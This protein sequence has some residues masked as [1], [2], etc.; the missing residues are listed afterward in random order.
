M[1][2][3]AAALTRRLA[4]ARR[5][6]QKAVKALGDEIKSSVTEAYASLDVPDELERKA[7]T[8]GGF[9][10]YLSGGGFRGWGYVL[11]SQHRVSPYPI[12]VINGFSVDRA[13]FM[14][15]QSIQT[16]VAGQDSDDEGIFR[17]SER[18]ASQVPA[19]AF[20]VTALSE[21]LPQIKNAQ[22]CQGGVREGFLFSSLPPAVRAHGPLEAATAPYA[23]PSSAH[24]VDLLNSALPPDSL[25]SA[26]VPITHDILSALANLLQHHATHPKDLIAPSALRCTTTGI[27]APVHGISHPDRALL[28]L[29]LHERWDGDVPPTDLDFLQRLRDLV[30]PRAAWWTMYLGRVGRLVGSMYP[31]GY[32]PETRIAFEAAWTETK[33]GNEAIGLVVRIGGADGE[34]ESFLKCVKGIEQMGKKKNWVGG[35]EG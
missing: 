4:E 20:L 32:A 15:T 6:G 12:P 19:V 27:L 31:A 5:G 33:K 8:E 16:A 35:K 24:I 17:V 2:F 23:T 25:G 11:M 14:D 29:L 1:P 21:A 30:G 18:R 3:G 13:D 7:R 34:T 28:A 9:A 10:L 26:A 22:F